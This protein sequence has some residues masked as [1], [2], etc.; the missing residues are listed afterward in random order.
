MLRLNAN[1][2]GPYP[3]ILFSQRRVLAAEA[4][5]YCST[6]A[7]AVREPLE[8]TDAIG[9]PNLTFILLSTH[10]C[11]SATLEAWQGLTLSLRLAGTENE[12]RFYH[13]RSTEPTLESQDS[14]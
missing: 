3:A 4:M 12:L 5:Q 10:P 13:A 6:D 2:L 7:G 1:E 14:S 8:R 9:G 11:C